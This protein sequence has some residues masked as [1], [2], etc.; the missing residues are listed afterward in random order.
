MSSC[1]LLGIS[2]FSVAYALLGIILLCVSLYPVL[3]WAID[4]PK[5]DEFVGDEISFDDARY[6]YIALAV[7]P[8]LLLVSAL[9]LYKLN[10]WGARLSPIALVMQILTMGI[11]GTLLLPV[12]AAHIVYFTRPKVKEIF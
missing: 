4:S 11:W 6:I 2:L 8:V 10:L 7:P 5:L 12:L 3:L 1:R 9:L